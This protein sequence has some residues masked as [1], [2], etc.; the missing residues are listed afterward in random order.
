MRKSKFQNAFTLVETMVVL[1]VFSVLAV[2]VTF[3]IIT[4]LRTTKKSEN[5]YRIRA[6]MD[7]AMEVM[8]RNLRNAKQISGVCGTYAG[9]TQLNYIDQYG[10]A[11]SFTCSGGSVASGSSQLLSSTEILLSVCTFD[12]EISCANEPVPDSVTIKLTGSTAQSSGFDAG[13]VSMENKILL[14]NY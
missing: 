5:L 2:L 1:S 11:S 10:N 12:I 14:R 3:I 7:A 13:N 9:Q 6:E 4:S 8:E